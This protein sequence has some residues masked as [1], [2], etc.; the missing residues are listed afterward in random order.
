[1][2]AHKSKFVPALFLNP[3]TIITIQIVENI[4]HKYYYKRSCM[5]RDP[6][7]PGMVIPCVPYFFFFVDFMNVNA[8]N[9][10]ILI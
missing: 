8:K 9:S 6:V 3:G 2:I 5:F 7:T 1:M 4:T 10:W